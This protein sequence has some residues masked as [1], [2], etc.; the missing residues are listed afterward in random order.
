MSAFL[1]IK[2]NK[3]GASQFTVHTHNKSEWSEED[4]THHIE[5]HK[6]YFEAMKKKIH[7]ELWF[8]NFHDGA[9]LYDVSINDYEPKPIRCLNPE[10]TYT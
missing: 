2:H 4:V 6:E 8:Y 5:S 1:I 3:N 10:G 9:V 7:W